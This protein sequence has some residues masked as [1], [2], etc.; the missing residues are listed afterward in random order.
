MNYKSKAKNERDSIR[1]ARHALRLAH[2]INRLKI[3]NCLNGLNSFTLFLPL[4]EQ[5][6]QD[7]L[8]QRGFS[9]CVW[10]GGVSGARM[11]VRTASSIRSPSHSGRS[12][13]S[14]V[15]KSLFTTSSLA[16]SGWDPSSPATCCPERPLG[17]LQ[18]KGEYTSFYCCSSAAG[19]QRCATSGL[20]GSLYLA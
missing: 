15:S 18:A 17:S 7:V 2:T 16:G 3:S 10:V 11:R 8:V 4:P 1:A 19:L 12:S 6:W 14:V 20:G 9:W 5:L 13:G